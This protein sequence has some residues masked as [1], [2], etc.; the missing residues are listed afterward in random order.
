[1]EEFADRTLGLTIKGHP[2]A[3]DDVVQMLATEVFLR[4]CKDKSAALVAAEKNPT[5]IFKAC[6]YVKASM[7]NQRALG[8]SSSVRQVR[9]DM[10]HEEPAVRGVGHSSTSSTSTTESAINDYSKLAT[11]I[12]SQFDRLI[13]HI[14]TAHQSPRPGSP[15]G[16]N[17][18]TANSPGRF[19]GRGRGAMRPFLIP[20]PTRVTSSP[21][22]PRSAACFYCQEMGHFARECPKKRQ[23]QQPGS[24]AKDQSPVT[25]DLNN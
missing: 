25:R 5:T 24:P 21:S 3:P 1:M 19:A 11:L 2:T 9:F 12:Q 8:R 13:T 22:S 17:P 18:A 20:S 10:D 23:N 6:K 4:G 16:G 14:G 15:G 7:H